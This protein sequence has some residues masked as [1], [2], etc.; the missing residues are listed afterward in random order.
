MDLID[1]M[2]TK[3]GMGM[4]LVTHDPRMTEFSNRTIQI[5]DGRLA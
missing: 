4:L 2:R 5:V 3:R 1:D